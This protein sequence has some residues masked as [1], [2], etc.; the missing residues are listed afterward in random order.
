VPI[1]AAIYSVGLVLLEQ[2]KRQHDQSDQ[3]QQREKA[4]D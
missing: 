4:L 1:A 2:A 3:D